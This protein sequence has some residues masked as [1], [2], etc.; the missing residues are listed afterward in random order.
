VQP[1]FGVAGLSPLSPDALSG[2][3]DLSGRP[4]EQP[5]VDAAAADAALNQGGYTGPGWGTPA[6]PPPPPTSQVPGQP[7]PTPPAGQSGYRPSASFGIGG[8]VAVYNPRSPYG[9]GRKYDERYVGLGTALKLGFKKYAKFKGRSSRS[10]FW[11]FYLFVQA[12]FWGLATAGGVA[13]GLAFRNACGSLQNLNDCRPNL[14]PAAIPFGL[15]LLWLLVIFVPTIAIMCRRLQ[16][17]D[18]NGSWVWL[19][20]LSGLLSRIPIV[21][22]F[23]NLG[24]LIL[25][26]VWWV[27]AGDMGPNRFGLPPD[28]GRARIERL[29]A[30][31]QVR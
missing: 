11:W 4:I 9:T 2:G 5:V 13:L 17:T 20:I 8:P 12:V 7:W 6:M 14:A 28:E 19:L 1:A 10:E 22:K 26:I 15:L 31:Q 27:F 30:R 23:I 29:V 3:T 16:D 25:F 24:V 21:G 18:R